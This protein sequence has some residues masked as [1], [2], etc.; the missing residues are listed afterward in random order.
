MTYWVTINTQI[1]HLNPQH[2]FG[3]N[4]W[5]KRRG[6]R[7]RI[8]KAMAAGMRRRELLLP[9]NKSSFLGRFRPARTEPSPAPPRWRESRQRL[10]RPCLL[11]SCRKRAKRTQRHRHTPVWAALLTNDC[12]GREFGPRPRGGSDARYWLIITIVGHLLLF[13]NTLILSVVSIDCFDYL[14]IYLGYQ[15]RIRHRFINNGYWLSI[16]G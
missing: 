15:S 2:L 10:R 5:K 4:I 3:N 11:P 12:S 7:R 6:D 13:N 14:L 9:G 16:D 8:I 1:L